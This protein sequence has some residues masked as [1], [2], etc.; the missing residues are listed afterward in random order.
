MS[1]DWKLSGFSRHAGR[2][3]CDGNLSEPPERLGRLFT[4]LGGFIS[5]TW[6]GPRGERA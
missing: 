5:A 4:V 2:R 6:P 3:S 1:G